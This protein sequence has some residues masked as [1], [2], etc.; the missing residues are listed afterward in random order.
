M[1]RKKG[2]SCLT[3]CLQPPK[4]ADRIFEVSLCLQKFWWVPKIVRTRNDFA[5]TDFWQIK[6]NFAQCEQ[7]LI[8]GKYNYFNPY[9][10][11]P[12]LDDGVEAVASVVMEGD[13][14]SVLLKTL[15]ISSCLS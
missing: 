2:F 4:L 3:K 8:E 1:S 7:A 10:R 11:C 6:Q 5:L 9:G 12:F 15:F 13:S 14:D